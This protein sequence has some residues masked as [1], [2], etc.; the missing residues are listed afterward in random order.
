MSKISLPGFYNGNPTRRGRLTYIFRNK[1]VARFIDQ[2]VKTALDLIELVNTQ[3]HI[4]ESDLTEEQINALQ[5]KIER[6]LIYLIE[7]GIS[8]D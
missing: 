6:T 8:N 2:D 7:T 5:A 3:T 1:P 4:A